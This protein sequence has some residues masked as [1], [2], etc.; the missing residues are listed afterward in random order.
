M[1]A[2][3]V[4]VPAELCTETKVVPAGS[5]SE[6]VTPVSVSGPLFVTT[7]VQVMLPSPRF[8]EAGEPLFVTDRS[9]SGAITSFSSVHLLS[10]GLLFPSPE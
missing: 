9:T 6:T 1:I 7:I 5:G 8:C 4:H 3:P 2:P 10:A